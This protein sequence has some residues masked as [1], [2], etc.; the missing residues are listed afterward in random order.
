MSVPGQFIP[1]LCALSCLDPI[2]HQTSARQSLAFIADTGARRQFEKCQNNMTIHQRATSSDYFADCDFSA[3]TG[4][5]E[6]DCDHYDSTSGA[7]SESPTATLPSVLS[8]LFLAPTNGNGLSFSAFKAQHQTQTQLCHPIVSQSGLHSQAAYGSY[9]SSILRPILPTAYG[10]NGLMHPLTYPTTGYI[11]ADQHFMN[12]TTPMLRSHS[13]S[14]IFSGGESKS[15][16]RA[17]SYS[18]LPP[19]SDLSITSPLGD[20]IPTLYSGNWWPFVGERSDDLSRSPKDNPATTPD[21]SDSRTSTEP[22][23]IIP[24]LD[25]DPLVPVAANACAFYPVPHTEYLST[26]APIISSSGEYYY[27]PIHFLPP[28]FSPYPFGC[29]PQQL[30]GGSPVLSGSMSRSQ[31]ILLTESMSVP[32]LLGEDPNAPSR[33][34]SSPVMDDKEDDTDQSNSRT[35]AA[36]YKRGRISIRRKRGV[37]PPSPIDTSVSLNHHLS[38]S[39]GV[40]PGTGASPRTACSQTTPGSA[41]PPQGARGSVRVA[42]VNCKKSCKK[43][44]DERPC[45]RCIRLKIE[46]TCVDAPRKDRNLRKAVSNRDIQNST[47]IDYEGS[48]GSR[49]MPTGSSITHSAMPALERQPKSAMSPLGSLINSPHQHGTSLALKK[50]AHLC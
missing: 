14:V 47:G 34:S 15:S 29:E 18:E 10:Y 3:L 25:L 32:A 4:T 21:N 49:G 19:L 20:D 31:R 22:S 45:P 35:S 26:V 40:T 30:I 16:G 5:K 9:G 7:S 41:H 27:A 1:S 33:K 48:F 42:C 37:K 38:L 8:P 43:C 11:R 12:N 6:N 46:E 2:H 24:P 28:T 36:S 44:M 13:D 39:S 17:M 50:A 23:P